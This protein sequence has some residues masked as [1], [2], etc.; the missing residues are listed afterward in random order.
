MILL[1]I[2]AGCVGGQ[3]EVVVE[4]ENAGG[5]EPAPNATFASPTPAYEQPDS[6]PETPVAIPQRS[7]RDD[8]NVTLAEQSF[9]DRLEAYRSDLGLDEFREDPRLSRIARQKAYDM[10]TRGY[11]GHEDPETGGNGIGRRLARYDYACAEAAEL[12][13]K[14]AWKTPLAG[15]GDG[16]INLTTE[17]Q[18]A[19]HVLSGLDDSEPHR[20]ELRQANRTTVGVGMY[21]TAEGEV[22]TTVILCR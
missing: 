19:D 1:L 9:I 14:T 16:P 20:E 10:G 2:S 17:Q 8:I 5:F 18:L 21:V 12:I 4:S 11:F 7:P 3:Q 22:Y 15:S 13:S 6:R